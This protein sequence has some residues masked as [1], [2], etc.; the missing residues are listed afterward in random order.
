MLCGQPEQKYGVRV[1]PGTAIIR[2][3]SGTSAATRRASC[4]SG[5]IGSSRRA[6]TSASI[7]GDN[8]PVQEISRAPVSSCLP[9]IRSGFDPG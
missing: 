4:N 5:N 2:S 7:R 3:C 6:S 8:S 9:T 1:A